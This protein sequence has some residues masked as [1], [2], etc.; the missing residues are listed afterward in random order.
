MKYFCSRSVILLETSI[1]IDIR[2]DIINLQQRFERGNFKVLENIN[3]PDMLCEKRQITRQKPL[4]IGRLRRNDYPI[5]LY[6]CVYFYALYQIYDS[7]TFLISSD[8]L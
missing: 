7:V 3:M 4:L 2:V 6:D 1:Q 8:T 5:S